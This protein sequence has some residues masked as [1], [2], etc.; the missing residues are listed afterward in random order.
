[1]R[2]RVFYH[3]ID[4]KLNA[5]MFAGRAPQVDYALRRPRKQKLVYRSG[6]AL[7]APKRLTRRSDVVRNKRSPRSEVSAP[8]PAT[9][10]VASGAGV[11]H[12]NPLSAS[13]PERTM[14]F[15]QIWSGPP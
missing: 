7:T 10:A 2:A 3:R 11:E 12:R 8:A 4:S 15:I 6:F 9:N 5:V 1:M 13:R 14:Q